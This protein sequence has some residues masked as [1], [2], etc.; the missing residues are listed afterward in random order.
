[1]DI[2]AH[3]P[4]RKASGVKPVKKIIED[5]AKSSPIGS[6]RNLP[7]AT[8]R[9][10]K[11]VSI[12]S[13]VELGI[14]KISPRSRPNSAKKVSEDVVESS[15]VESVLTPPPAAT[16]LRVRKRIVIATPE[17]LGVGKAALPALS[18]VDSVKEVVAKPST[19][20]PSVE[21]IIRPLRVKKSDSIVV[22]GASE[23]AKSDL[24]SRLAS[25]KKSDKESVEKGKTPSKTSLEFRNDP[26]RRELEKQ[27]QASVDHLQRSPVKLQ[28][29]PFYSPHKTS[30]TTA[31]GRAQLGNAHVRKQLFG[32]ASGDVIPPVETPIDPIPPANSPAKCLKAGDEASSSE[33]P[34]ETDSGLDGDQSIHQPPQ[35]P[36]KNRLCSALPQRSPGKRMLLFSPSKGLVKASLPTASSVHSNATCEGLPANVTSAQDAYTL[37]LAEQNS[38][39]KRKAEYDRSDIKKRVEEFRALTSKSRE[40]RQEGSSLLASLPPLNLMEKKRVADDI[41]QCPASDSSILP[42]PVGF[43]K[44]QKLFEKL[45]SLVSLNRRQISYF[46]KIR[47]NSHMQEMTAKLFGRPLEY[48]DLGQIK[49]IFPEAFLFRIEKPTNSGIGLSS[50]SIEQEQMA[51]LIRNDTASDT[52]SFLAEPAPSDLFRRAARFEAALLDIVHR[53]HAAFIAALTPAL[54]VERSQIVAWHPK[55]LSGLDAVELPEPAAM[56]QFARPRIGLTKA[57]V[58][59]RMTATTPESLLPRDGAD[60]SESA[61]VVPQPVQ[62][63]TPALALHPT[64]KKL[65][66]AFLLRVQANAAKRLAKVITRDPL[67]E[68]ELKMLERIPAMGRIISNI[69]TDEKKTC[70]ALKDLLKSLRDSMPS[71][72]LGIEEF[73]QHVLLLLKIFKGKWLEEVELPL[74]AG[75]YV[76]IHDPSVDLKKIEAIVKEEMDIRRKL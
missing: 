24:L 9:V 61:A 29:S 38:S 6:H 5:A 68:K 75:K 18:G 37:R 22:T 53:K 69:F 52:D 10:K 74:T 48:T 13:L 34:A 21:S 8:L 2:R 72:K 39:V 31:Q 73:N 54:Y 19:S 43:R 64:L 47:D 23:N 25:S 16:A 58:F 4:T 26:K 60:V 1:M 30:L 33:Q 17:E 57:E 3:F 11:P 49:A 20:S 36:V 56:P 27:F 28:L 62:P 67:V 66:P 15:L 41:R 70:L 59:A 42:L 71:P 46:D 12:G 44:Y 45:D 76:K 55:F 51:I 65:D 32:K 63:T 7:P 40:R 14:G 50:V 35:T